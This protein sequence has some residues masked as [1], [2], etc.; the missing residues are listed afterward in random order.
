[1]R[2]TDT[3]ETTLR[4]RCDD[5]A[6]EWTEI[7]PEGLAGDESYSAHDDPKPCDCDSQYEIL[8]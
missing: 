1:M 3:T 7:Y 6:A 5:C 2:D 4:V 8:A